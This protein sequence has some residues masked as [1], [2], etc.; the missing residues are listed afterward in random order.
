MKTKK[1]TN[2]QIH[3]TPDALISLVVTE[4][5]ERELASLPSLE[6][7]NKEFQP[8]ENFQ[9]KMN[10]LLKKARRKEEWGNIWQPTKKALTVLTTVVTVLTC[11]FLPAK[12]V[13][14]AV[15]NTI[16]QWQDKFIDI[17]YSVDESDNMNLN[18]PLH[19]KLNYVPSG[20][21]LSS[22]TSKSDRYMARYASDGDNW[23][24]IRIIAIDSNQSVS[25]DAEFTKYYSIKF[26][27]HNAIWGIRDD[28]SNSLVWE[29]SRLSYELIGDINIS[30]LLRIA[31][32]ITV[33]ASST[34]S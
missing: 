5:E 31:E 10:R 6:E 1:G 34:G 8:S 30:E 24:T 29:E 9:K 11:S 28:S 3:I 18:L 20:Y 7:M 2:E 21:L 19:V 33:T 17:V 26:D 13:Q 22:E 23:Y 4:A 27:D 14:D 25:L 16:I 15:V 12:A 32:G